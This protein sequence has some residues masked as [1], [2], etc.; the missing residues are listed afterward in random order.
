MPA[1]YTHQII[2]EKIYARLPENICREIQRLPEYCLGA[3]GGD[4]FYFLRL[5][6]RSEKNW[7][8]RLHNVSIYEVFSAL[9]DAFRVGSTEVRSYVAGYIAHYAADTVFHPFVYGM[10]Q[11]LANER[12]QWRGRW[13]SYIESDLDTY[14]VQRYKTVPIGDY[15]FPVKRR[16]LRVQAVA[17]ILPGIGGVYGDEKISERSFRRAIARYYRFEKSF[18]DRK[19]RRRRLYE[20]AEKL[21]RLPHFFST[22][23]RREEMDVRCLNRAEEL[24]TNP[25]APESVSREDADRLLE[26]AVCE[27]VRLIGR[28]FICAEGGVPLPREEFDRGFLSGVCCERPSVRPRGGADP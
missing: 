19:G 26:R 17:S 23:C 15:R 16:E 12:P 13:H 3:Q 28:F 5:L 8:R 14:F 11:R 22:L 2:A 21:F 25:S 7:G 27:G 18:S 20:G 4:V 1:Q 6:C 24:W 9:L 10:T